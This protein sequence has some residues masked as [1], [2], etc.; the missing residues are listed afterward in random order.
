MSRTSATFRQA[1]VRRAW[2][3]ARKDGKEVVRTEL[4]R[5]VASYWS[6]SLTQ[7]S[8]PPMR[9]SKHGKRGDMRIRL[10][11]LN[12]VVKTLADGSVVTYYYAW[13]GGIRLKGKLGTPEFIANTEPGPR[14]TPPHPYP[15]RYPRPPPPP[16][17]PPHE[18]L[19]NLP[20]HHETYLPR[21]P[22]DPTGMSPEL[23]SY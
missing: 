22:P 17:P 14:A 21:N 9:H 13:K 6:T 10:K 20:P 7:R 4:D 15:P 23:P 19:S 12:S 18:P 5:T 1:D 8:R 3:A 11:G 2:A 16:H